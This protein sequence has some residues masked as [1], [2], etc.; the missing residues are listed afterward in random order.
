MKMLATSHVWKQA[1]LVV[2]RRSAAS[3]CRAAPPRLEGEGE[4]R[5]ERG[6]AAVKVGQLGA[7]GE[8]RR[9]TWTFDPKEPR[10]GAENISRPQL[11][12]ITV[13]PTLRGAL[14]RCPW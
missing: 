6:P 8:A 12:P 11:R 10:V 1:P 3:P 13:S 2:V 9:G 7:T 14:R 4:R 5:Q